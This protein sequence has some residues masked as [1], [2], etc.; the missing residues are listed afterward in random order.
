[1]RFVGN[2][3]EDITVVV[4]GDL[5]SIYGAEQVAFRT[6]RSLAEV[7]AKEELRAQLAKLPVASAE[8]ATLEKRIT[9]PEPWSGC[10][11]TLL[12]DDRYGLFDFY[13]NPIAPVAGKI[14]IPLD[15]RGFYLRGDGKPG[16]AAALVAA[17][18]SGRIDGLSPVALQ[19]ADARVPVDAHMPNA[20]KAS[21]TLSLT[22]VLNRPVTGKITATIEGLTIAQPEPVTV[23]P[24]ATIEVPLMVIG[25]KARPDNRYPCRVVADFGA[26]GVI[27]LYEDVRVDLIDHRTITVDGKLE[28]W[29]NAIPQ[30]VEF[31]GAQTATLTEKA[32]LPFVA[33]D[34]AVKKGVAVSWLAY[35]EAN[36]YFASRINDTSPSEGLPRFSDN[37]FWD[38]S[39]YPAVS[40]APASPRL[41]DVSMRWTGHV[42]APTS[43]EYRFATISD[44]GVRLWLDGKQLVDNWTGHGAVEDAGTVILE[45]GKR[46]EVKLEWFQGGGKA[47]IQL[48]WTSPGKERAVIPTAAL[49][50]AADATAHGL[51]C[52]V[53]RGTDL[54]NEFLSKID[55]EVDFAWSDGPLT[56]ESFS[57]SQREE[58]RWPDGVRRY[59]YRSGPVLPAGN[60]PN[61]DNVQIAFNV[62]PPEAKSEYP[63]PPGTFPGLTNCPT[64]DYEYALNTVAQRYG[65]GTEVWRLATPKMPP[66]HFYPRQPASPA[67]GAVPGAQLVTSHVGATRIV[68]C[69]IPWAE[70]PEV[71]AAML[72]GTPVGFTYRVN[73]DAGVGCM[74]LARGRSVSRRGRAFHADWLEHWENQLMFSWQK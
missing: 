13:G 4:L 65:G 3:P 28:D 27:P 67:D 74:E 54:K 34:E 11:L 66:K 47:K 6:C 23:P 60:A 63:C 19:L 51:N 69:A 16:S 21:F 38:E 55:P 45:A 48:L 7:G 29:A 70:L 20:A 40:Y 39:F 42:L 2:D 43:G 26:D 64:T 17:V 9:T 30:P 46:Y 68:E 49:F 72:A 31:S 10:T 1:M 18:K 71:H 24:G 53:F 36:F 57:G 73:D 50:T 12:A 41:S 59:S 8:R 25:G 61:A 56:K 32:W 35:D 52:T 14:T 33:A 44:D 58:L 22:N 62:L 5:G 37:G 15:A